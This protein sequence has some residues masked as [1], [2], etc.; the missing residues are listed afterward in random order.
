MIEWALDNFYPQYFHSQVVVER[1]ILVFETPESALVPVM[2]A[3][4]REF[5]G[6]RAFSLPSIGDGRDGRP[7][8][9]HI[10][11]GVKGPAELVDQAFEVIERGVREMALETAPVR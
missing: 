3:I 1:S 2:E 6:I 4:E 7:A 9:R 8:R 11:L 5:I 10:E